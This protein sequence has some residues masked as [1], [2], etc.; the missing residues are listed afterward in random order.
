MP[1]YV[2]SEVEILDEGIADVYKALAAASIANYGGQYLVR[3]AETE[4]VEGTPTT[5]R[6]V[7]VEFPSI[8]QARIWYSSP[9]YAEALKVRETA[10]DRRLIFVEGIA[11]AT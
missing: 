9:A 8:E 5:R 11:V 10:L 3:G 1:A 4:V 2:I 7:I 6:I